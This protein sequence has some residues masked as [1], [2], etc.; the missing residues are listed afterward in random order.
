MRDLTVLV[1]ASG[2][3][4]TAALIRALRMNGER[5]AV[6]IAASSESEFAAALIDWTA[7]RLLAGQ[8]NRKA[9]EAAFQRAEKARWS[10]D[11]SE[12]LLDY[13]R[14]LAAAGA[15]DQAKELYSNALRENRAAN[16]PVASALK[17]ALR[18]LEPDGA[19]TS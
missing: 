3:P 15:T 12:F 5:E 9:G 18:A 1:T 17:Q 14:F 4:G 16:S 8:G 19:P 7:A 11:R 10:G 13:G 6:R 2:A